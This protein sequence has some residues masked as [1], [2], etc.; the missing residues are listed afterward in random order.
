[1]WLTLI[2]A[3]VGSAV[4]PPRNLGELCIGVQSCIVNCFGQH[5]VPGAST[6]S[7][8]RVYSGP[9][10]TLFRALLQPVK[11]VLYANCHKQKD[12]PWAPT[13]SLVKSEMSPSQRDY[14]VDATATFEKFVQGSSE[15]I[16]AAISDCCELTWQ[17]RMEWRPGKAGNFAATVP[18]FILRCTN[19]V[20]IPSLR[21]GTQCQ[22]SF[23]ART[24]FSCELDED[25]DS[26]A[27]SSEQRTG[28]GCRFRLSESS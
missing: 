27:L 25:G 12:Q 9:T 3:L 6:P 22:D 13:C 10:K 2:L 15:A 24:T 4:A 7:A 11:G 16:V 17:A 26:C 20:T 14:V 18:T 21:T 19:A 8:F 1:M 5:V 23:A 28:H